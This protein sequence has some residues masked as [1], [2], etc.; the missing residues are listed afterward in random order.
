VTNPRDY[1][2]EIRST[3]IG[4]LR[5]SVKMLV[6]NVDGYTIKMANRDGGRRSMIPRIMMGN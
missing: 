1:P 5:Q 3:D 4:L 2:D 6:I